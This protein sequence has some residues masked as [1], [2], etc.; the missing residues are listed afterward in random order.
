MW[1]KRP[2]QGLRIIN[3]VGD[4]LNQSKLNLL[5]N[6][7]DEWGPKFQAIS[8]AVAYTR[9]GPNSISFRAASHMALVMLTPQPDREMALSSE[10]KSV[11]LA[12]VGSVEIIPAD[13]DLFARWREPKE[14][15]LLAHAPDQLSRLVELEFEAASFEFRPP[16]PG[17]VDDKALILAGMVREEFLRGCSADKLYFDSLI[18]VLSTYLLRSYSTLSDRKRKISRGGLS[19]KAW[20]DTQEYIRAHIAD[21]LSIDR[22][23]IVANLSPSHFLRAFRQKAGQSPHQYVLATRLELAEQLITT[24]SL[25][26]REIAARGGFSSHSHMS[27]LMRERKFTTPSALR[28]ARTGR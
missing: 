8:G 3:V 16:G 5:E 24:T 19:T 17:H 22:L 14:N 21:E 7:P 9:T 1:S 26:L 25:P 20:R 18:T 13:A 15:L 10:R 28:R 4:V 2:S 11:F 6:I 23:A 27:A 12:P